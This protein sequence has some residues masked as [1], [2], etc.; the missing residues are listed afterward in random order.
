MIEI[1]FDEETEPEK[2]G[3]STPARRGAIEALLTGAAKEALRAAG[4]DPQAGLTIVMADDDRLH[5]LN[6]QFLG[7]DAPTDV[8]SF[9]G[10]D[11]DPDTETVYLGDI[12]ISYERASAHALIGGHA[13]DA[14]LQLLA[15][16]GVLHLL[17][18]DHA[19]PGEKTEMWALQ[20]RILEAL[21]CPLRP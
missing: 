16:H 7:V 10:G 9:P 8:L 19:E 15:V 2:T 3:A 14:E 21:G 12:L 6:R 13:V 4:T 17:G 11:T 1:I 18:Y 20:A 5:A